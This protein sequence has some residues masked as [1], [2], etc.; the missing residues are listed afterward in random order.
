MFKWGK[1]VVAGVTFFAGIVPNVNASFIWYNA[2]GYVVNSATSE[3]ESFIGICIFEDVDYSGYDPYKPFLHFEY[4]IRDF[5]ITSETFGTFTGV[6]GSLSYFISD[7]YLQLL[8]TGFTDELFGDIEELNW[9]EEFERWGNIELR[10]YYSFPCWRLDGDI[11][12]ENIE[13]TKNN[14]IPEP[15]VHNFMALGMIALFLL[16]VGMLKT[17]Q[18]F[19]EH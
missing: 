4:P 18:R 16:P 14:L 9:D 8:G 19:T 1:I 15:G 13:L 7:T 12:F 17:R 6:R 2:S 11:Y 5:Y 10:D 3:Y